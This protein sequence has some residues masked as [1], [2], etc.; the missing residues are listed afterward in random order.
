MNIISEKDEILIKYATQLKK[1]EF[2]KTA[3]D[4]VDVGNALGLDTLLGAGI[5]A[6]S[7]AAAGTGIGAGIL[8]GLGIGTGVI[9]AVLAAAGVAYTVYQ[10][11]QHADDNVED[12][13]SRLD[14]LD[15]ND[16]ARGVVDEWMKELEQFKNIF[17][18]QVKSQDPVQ[19]ANQIKEQIKNIN[20]LLAYLKGIWE[21]WGPEVKPNLTDWGFDAKQAENALSKTIQATEAGLA[22]IRQSA[23]QEGT[24][25]VQQLGK[26]TG[27]NYTS[28]A[29]Q[30]VDLHNQ[31]TQLD[32]N[33]PEYE[34]YEKPAFQL[35]QNI[36]AGKAELQDI[37]QYGSLMKNLARD[38]QKVLVQ[39]QRKHKKSFLKPSISKRAVHLSGQP[40]TQQVKQQ[41]PKEKKEVPAVAKDP[42]VSTLQKSLNYLNTNLKTNIPRIAEDGN[43]STNT[44][45]TLYALLEKYPVIENYMSRSVGINKEDVKDTN[46]MKQ[47][48]EYLTG[49]SGLLSAVVNKM[50]P[51]GQTE[52][53][54]NYE[55]QYTGQAQCR[56]DKEDPSPEEILAC[57]RNRMVRD[58]QT[59]Q[60]YNAYE[61]LKQKG[62]RDNDIVAL[63]VRLFR[64][65][66][67][68][69]WSMP[70]LLKYVSGPRFDITR[71]Y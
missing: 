36:L 59:E 19:R 65:A 17:Q 14:A 49:I 67:S 70:L 35:A 13:I 29:K 43:Y 44:S 23:Q 71:G 33:P 38:L 51:Q 46:L 37:N 56:E 45:N 64:G 68:E 8:G 62:M 25:L 34:E 2:Q 11:M 7:A 26:Q 9:P 63:M 48:K 15:P 3:W 16:R 60:Y 5:G 6:G 57:L 4:W 10:V 27:F 69:D 22:Q 1:A 55:A 30:V 20:A 54:P 66:K 12:L 50:K 28:L 42:V 58:P 53:K 52:Q 24:K 21:Q 40:N 31:I 18:I 47:D 61:Y 32:G 39:A 41:Q